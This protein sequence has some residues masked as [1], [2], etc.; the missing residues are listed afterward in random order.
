MLS[1]S[2]IE[3]AFFKIGLFGNMS[4]ISVF[5]HSVYN[6]AIQTW[7]FQSKCKI[8]TNGNFFFGIAEVLLIMNRKYNFIDIIVSKSITIEHID[9][10]FFVINP[11][12]LS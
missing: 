6:I 11:L 5:H 9:S 4:C 10:I 2:Q 7:S 1:D 3:F 8:K 12:H